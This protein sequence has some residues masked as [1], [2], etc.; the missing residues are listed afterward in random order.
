MSIN[1]LTAEQLMN[2]PVLYQ[3]DPHEDASE[4]YSLISS[5][6]IIDEHKSYNW[7]PTSVQTASV[8]ET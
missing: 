8:K 4:K 2:Y 5:I 1:P 3:T 7:Y 6:D